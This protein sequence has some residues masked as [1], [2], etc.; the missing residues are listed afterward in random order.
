MLPLIG[1]V[2]YYRG[3]KYKVN[4]RVHAPV[5]FNLCERCALHTGEKSVFLCCALSENFKFTCW[6]DRK[7]MYYFEEI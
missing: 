7:W 4:K 5:E 3:H 2:I 6:V 1:S